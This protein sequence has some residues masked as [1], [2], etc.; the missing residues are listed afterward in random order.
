[1]YVGQVLVELSPKIIWTY[2]TDVKK[3]SFAN[4]PLIAGFFDLN[5]SPPFPMQFEP[6]H[7]VSVVAANLFD[8]TQT[9][10]DLF[11]LCSEWSK[12]IP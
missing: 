9:K 3:D 5:F 12:L 4:I 1:M 11:N 2:H 6:T 7:M 8:N 10:Y